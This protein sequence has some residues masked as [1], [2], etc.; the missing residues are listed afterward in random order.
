[1]LVLDLLLLVL[2]LIVNG[3]VAGALFLV[4]HH[5][6]LV[7][8]RQ[9]HVMPVIRRRWQLFLDRGL[10]RQQLLLLLLVLEICGCALWLLPW[11]LI[12]QKGNRGHF[13][14]NRIA[15]IS[16]TSRPDPGAGCCTVAASA[17]SSSP[18]RSSV[19]I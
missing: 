13:R 17:S 9:L 1:M 14:G 11:L 6:G 15:A 2:E 7:L 4:L 10:C 16:R 8:G 5:S 19:C 18:A 3:L 12:V